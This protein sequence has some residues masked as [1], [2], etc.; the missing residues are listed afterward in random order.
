MYIWMYSCPMTK[1]YS[2]SEARASLPT[3]VDE[4]E[5]GA[6]VELTRRGEPVAVVLSTRLY[7][8]LRADR[9]TFTEAYKRFRERVDLDMIGT[10]GDVFEDLR[11]R[12]RGRKV[13]L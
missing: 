6:E 4:V 3:L 8:R 1:K 13:D 5:A 7:E 9:P 12:G 10:D 11:D 2:I